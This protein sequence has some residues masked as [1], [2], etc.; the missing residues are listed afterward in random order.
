MFM[1]IYHLHYDALQ[2]NLQIVTTQ[3]TPYLMHRHTIYYDNKNITMVNTDHI[4]L[5]NAKKITV[6]L[7]KKFST[8][9]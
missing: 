6:Y 8:N 4:V 7:N 1:V 5:K 9:L 3:H 2:N